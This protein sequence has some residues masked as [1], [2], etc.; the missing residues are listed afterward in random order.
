MANN[1]GVAQARGIS[2]L[3]TS[4]APPPLL[5]L[6]AFRPTLRMNIRLDI[7]R[8]GYIHRRHTLFFKPS[9]SVKIQTTL[10]NNPSLKGQLPVTSHPVPVVRCPLP[11]AYRPYRFPCLFNPSP[12]MFDL[13]N[14][15]HVNI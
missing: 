7:D 15:R 8:T 9:D 2:I 3:L 13:N 4:I 1:L 5:I 6:T 14:E 11:I 12:T 10:L